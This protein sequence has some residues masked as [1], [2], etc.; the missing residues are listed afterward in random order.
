MQPLTAPAR[1]PGPR[2]PGTPPTH[3]GAILPPGVSRSSGSCPL[4]RPPS[5]VS[6]LARVRPLSYALPPDR[7]AGAS[8]L[9]PSA[10]PG[11]EGGGQRRGCDSSRPDQCQLQP[12]FS[13]PCQLALSSGTEVEARAPCRRGGRPPAG[14]QPSTHPRGASPP[15]RPLAALAVGPARNWPWSLRPGLS[16]HPSRIPLSEL[17]GL[18][19]GAPSLLLE[20]AGL[21]ELEKDHEGG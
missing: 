14:P 12:R 20:P 10:C 19:G 5:R 3:P 18:A 11:G 21:D 17:T 2:G 16:P 4:C 7:E 9:P 15:S 6:T 8:S 13:A 1:S